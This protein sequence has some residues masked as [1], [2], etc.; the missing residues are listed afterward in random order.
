MAEQETQDIATLLAEAIKRPAAER[1]AFL[2]RVCAG[3]ASLRRDLDNLLTA[4][5]RAGDFLQHAAIPT[6]MVATAGTVPYEEVGSHIGPYKILQMIGEG[7]FGS[8]YLAE[9]EEPVRRRVALKIIKWGMDTRQVIA[10]FEAE[11]Q[12]LAIMDHPNIARVFDAGAT[13]HGRPYFVMELVKGEPITVYCDR[14]RLPLEERLDLF[15]HVCAAVQHAHQKGIIHRDIKPSNVLV[16]LHDGQPQPKVIDFGIAKATSA[17][18]TEKTLFT[19][20]RQLIGTP[21]YMSPEQAEANATDV[22]TRSDVY[23]LGVL[24]YELL[25]GSTPFDG[26]RLR[27]AA[28]GEMQ[29][30]IREEDPPKPSTRLSTIERLPT[31]ASQ[32]AIEPAKLRSELRGD[33]DWIVMRAIEKDRTRRYESASALSDDIRRHLHDEPVTAGSP[34][35]TYRLRKF[36]RRHRLQVIATSLVVLALV[37]GS[38]GTLVGMLRARD[39]ARI[40]GDEASKATA[41]NEFMSEVLTSV[42]PDERGMDVRL[43]EV[44][45]D[46]SRTASQRFAGH[47]ELEATVRQTLANVYVRL[48]NTPATM[49]ELQKVQAI[50]ESLG[51][52]DDQRAIA[53]HLRR[54]AMDIASERTSQAEASLAQVAPR[55]ARVLKPD[56]PAAIEVMRLEGMIDMLRGRYDEAERKL[57]QVRASLTAAGA[58]DLPH[59]EVLEGLIAVQRRR[60]FAAEPD[61]EG[62]SPQIPLINEV[63]ERTSRLYGPDSWWT[64][65]A[66]LRLAD[67]DWQ[68]GHYRSAADTC[69][70]VLEKTQHRYSECH[71]LREEANRVLSYALMCLGESKE[72]AD[73]WIKRLE[74]MRQKGYEPN[75]PIMIGALSDSLRVFERDGRGVEG[76][77]RAREVAAALANVGGTHGDMLDTANLYIARF[78]SLQGRIAEADTLFEALQS[79]EKDFDSPLQRARLRLFLAGHHVLQG[80]YEEAEAELNACTAIVGDV[81]LG[82][83]DG[84]PDDIVL[85]YVNLYHAWGKADKEAE[86]RAVLEQMREPP[87]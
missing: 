60:F 61:P 77:A 6:G 40:A 64:L 16:T 58:D 79:R 85:G 3:D 18:L 43:M 80:Q 2:D 47:P 83:L 35:A 15:Q 33:L 30:I 8:V 68:R 87:Q 45:D 19:E 81:R 46:A 71:G 14:H 25:T 62:L 51:G 34:G 4:H 23:S 54:V 24:L 57:L 67:I 84:T 37:G 76:E 28:F 26:Q 9:Q 49:Q 36:I 72:P 78:V 22:D 63:I 29:R 82:T 69:R 41:I 17:R 66:R 11:R 55:I 65:G 44:M 5:A 21:E 38:I 31:I 1:A 12:A 73:I 42:E 53:V 20:F 70:A 52:L 13:A 75:G 59:V 48:S 10:R 7:G 27:S 86:Y 74:C 32:R 39:S 56:S 50:W